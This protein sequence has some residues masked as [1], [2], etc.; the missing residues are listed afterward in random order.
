MDVLTLVCTLLR[1]NLSPAAALFFRVAPPASAS[2]VLAVLAEVCACVIFFDRLSRVV[3]FL[4]LHLPVARWRRF[5]PADLPAA[6]R[7]S[8]GSRHFSPRACCSHP[9]RLLAGP[10]RRSQLTAAVLW[11]SGTGPSVR[12]A[13]R[14]AGGRL[15]CAFAP[16]CRGSEASSILLE[17]LLTLW[18]MRAWLILRAGFR[19]ASSFLTEAWLLPP[20]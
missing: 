20:A 9:V 7:A 12:S 5:P 1:Q 6:L 16:A 11:R 13:L 4:P 8:A 10:P 19:P 15:N 18:R 17:H 3:S 14:R 2:A